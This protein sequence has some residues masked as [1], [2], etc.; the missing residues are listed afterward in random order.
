MA[1]FYQAYTKAIVEVIGQ[2]YVILV[3]QVLI[4]GRSWR[5]IINRS[6]EH[7]HELYA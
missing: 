3:A 5:E 7:V 4:P 6:S 2:I 1:L